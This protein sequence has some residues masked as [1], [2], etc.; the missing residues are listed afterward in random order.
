L[1]AAIAAHERAVELRVAGRFALA[2]PA[3][4]RALAGYQASEGGRHPDVA[5][6]LVELGVILEARDRPREAARC[7]RRALA[8]L[9]RPTELD[10]VRLALHA[11]IALAG[12]DRGRGALAAADVGLRGALAEA[13]RRL[14]PRDPLIA[15]V[16]NNLGVLRKA[17]GRYGEALAYYRRALPLASTRDRQARATLHH[18]L[19]GIEHARGNYA[20]AEPHAR[21]SVELRT[22]A[23]EPGHPA[24]AADLAAL[25]AIVEARGRFDE[26]AALYARA[27]AIFRGK[28]GRGSLEL[29]LGLASLAAL[30]QQ[31]GRL[32][33]A[34]RL[35]ARA[36]AILERLL[37]KHHTDV[38]MTV[39][40]LAVL[41]RDDGRNAR[42]RALF[43]RARASFERT[44]GARHPHT[45]LARDNHRAVRAR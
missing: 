20:Q 13:R 17:Q 19:G 2:E 28:L 10:L 42:A 41:E 18:N 5:N 7:H 30:E 43:R 29:G 21:R 4:R 26:A 9:G 16:L 25:A 44:L 45:R 6:A 38:A 14:P 1:Q 33:R 40:N 3:C 32:S 27:L 35:Y 12:L 39:N 15:S 8:I 11:K 22:A 24:V 23:L 34:R 36:L 31:R 37:G